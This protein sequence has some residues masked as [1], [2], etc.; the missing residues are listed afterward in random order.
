MILGPLN[1]MAQDAPAGAFMDDIRI[2]KKNAERLKRVI[3]QLLDFRKIENNKMGLRVT[4]MD[5]V[6]FNPRGEILF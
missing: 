5:L 3:D 1:K 2:V 4:K 6:F